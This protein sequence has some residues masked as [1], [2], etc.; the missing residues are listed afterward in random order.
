MIYRLYPDLLKKYRLISKNHLFIV[1]LTIAQSGSSNVA[2]HLAGQNFFWILS[3]S[4]KLIV[5]MVDAVI[6]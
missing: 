6:A 3:R 5:D 4:Q 2:L 1:Y